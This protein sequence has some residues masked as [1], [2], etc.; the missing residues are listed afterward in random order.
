MFL[1]RFLSFI[2]LITF[3]QIACAGGTVIPS[4]QD[5]ILQTCLANGNALGLTGAEIDAV[6][7][8]TTDGLRWT[9]ERVNQPTNTF[10][11]NLPFNSGS[12]SSTDPNREEQTLGSLLYGEEAGVNAGS[13]LNSI[14]VWGSASKSS[15][16]YTL[17]PIESDTGSAMIGAHTSIGETGLIGISFGIA[18]TDVKANYNG[19]EQELKDYSFAGYVGTMITDNISVGA[20][21]GVSFRDIDQFRINALAGPTFGQVI[22]SETESDTWFISGSIDGFWE[23][24]AFV[25][26]AHS[27]IFYSEEEVDGFTETGA[28][29]NTVASRDIETGLFRIGFDIGYAKPKVYEPYIGIAY[30]N[31]F[32]QPEINVLSSAAA[33]TDDDEFVGSAGIRFFGESI[34]GSVSWNRN[35]SRDFLDYDSLN[36]LLSVDL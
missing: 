19:G 33:D 22:N 3:G 27:S 7:P 20:N 5:S 17:I 35:F 36:L 9:V 8:A 2:L 16:E 31:Y 15:S 14:N 23:F 28:V 26:G 1:K 32:E 4:E 6:C 24:D 12:A 30:L 29:T 34:S 18:G 10:S 25:F 21:G 13:F 11:S